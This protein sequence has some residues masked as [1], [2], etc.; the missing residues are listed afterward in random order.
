M[1]VINDYLEVRYMQEHP[2]MWRSIEPRGNED[3]SHK[4]QIFLDGMMGHLRLHSIQSY[5][6]LCMEAEDHSLF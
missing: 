5:K 6:H 1:V 2:D 3:V 4:Y